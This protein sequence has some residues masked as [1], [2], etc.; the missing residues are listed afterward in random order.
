V[1]ARI[2]TRLALAFAGALTLLPV[3]AAPGWAASREPFPSALSTA[4][5]SAS[6]AVDSGPEAE[7]PTG[8]DATDAAPYEAYPAGEGYTVE[9]ASSAY[10]PADVQSVVNVL[11]ALEHGPELDRLSVYVATPEEISSICGPTVLACYMPARERMIV[12]GVDGSAGGVPRDF[13]IAHEYGHHIANSRRGT[14]FPA[15]AAGTARWSTY[16]RVCQLTRAHR[17]FPGDQGA[18]YWQNP[19]EAFAEA[20]AHLAE[21]QARVSW[22]Y[23]PSLRPRAASLAKIRADIVH[24]W[25]GPTT[26]IWNSSLGARVAERFIRTP[27]DGTVS[28]SIE[29][30]ADSE[31][32]AVLR[33]AEHGR[34]LARA[35]G[36]GNGSASVSYAN[37]GHRALLLQVRSLS[38]EGAFQATITTP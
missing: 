1:Q 11:G 16:E 33:D 38:G 13:A 3:I 21:P 2:T 17:L 18:H 25:S 14:P 10:T 22:Q 28:V 30:P 12:S 20:Y 4:R 36:G 27:F 6:D 35:V 37:C 23:V 31:Y 29:S 26:S 15:I 5:F 24:P 8:A 9:A 34:A 19:E 32:A 7:P